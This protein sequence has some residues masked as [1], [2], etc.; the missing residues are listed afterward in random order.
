MILTVAFGKGGTGKTTTVQCLYHAARRQGFKCLAIDTDPQANLTAA[1]GASTNAR[2]CYEVITG[3]A[4]A[5]DVIQATEQGDIITA[6]LRMS[7]AE[8]E[9]AAV[10]GS[11]LALKAALQP[12]SAKYDFIFIDTMPERTRLQ[13][14]SIIACDSVLLPMQ[15]NAF[16][17]MGLY[18]MKDTIN[19]IRN[20]PYLNPNLTVSGILLVKYNPRQNLARDLTEAIQ[21]EA[22]A[23]NTVVFDTHIRQGVDIEKAQAMKQS[24]FDYAPRCNPAIDYANLFEELKDRCVEIAYMKGRK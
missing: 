18:Q 15:A 13:V 10:P 11:D 16:S 5:A 17:I 3:K 19:Q 21:A 6:G 23:M 24:I 22:K 9:L 20:N 2:G 1:F 4:D 14:N 7:Q 8:N 12:I